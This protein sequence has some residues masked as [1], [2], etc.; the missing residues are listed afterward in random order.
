MTM[1]T[2]NLGVPD[3]LDRRALAVLGRDAKPVQAY[4]RRMNRIHWLERA[5]QPEEW[6]HRVVRVWDLEE[7]KRAERAFRPVHRAVWSGLEA[8][9]KAAD[10]FEA[11]EAAEDYWIVRFDPRFDQHEPPYVHEVLFAE[12]RTDIVGALREI[13]LDDWATVRFFRQKIDWYAKGHWCAAVTPEG[14]KV[15]Y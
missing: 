4:V 1:G 14:Q 2:E 8:I 9:G 12:I 10:R 11:M 5:G 15:V 13:V 7:A 6:D 3:D